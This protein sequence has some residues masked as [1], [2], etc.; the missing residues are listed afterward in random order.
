M[1]SFEDRITAMES[2]LALACRRAGASQQETTR[3]LT[4]AGNALTRIAL[5]GL[6]AEQ[7]M[8]DEGL[9]G[10]VMR[11]MEL[12]RLEERR[13]TLQAEADAIDKQIGDLEKLNEIITLRDA[14]GSLG[15][16]LP[17]RRRD[18]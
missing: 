4:E 18:D 15:V 1:K 13:A 12:C 10:A 2:E 9:H 7:V 3:I 11:L 17:L 5:D 8:R 14:L 6:Q 16:V